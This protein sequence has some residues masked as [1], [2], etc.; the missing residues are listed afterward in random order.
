VTDVLVKAKQIFSLSQTKNWEFI[1]RLSSADDLLWEDKLKQITLCPEFFPETWQVKSWAE[2][3]FTTQFVKKRISSRGAGI[4]FAPLAHE[5]VSDYIV[6]NKLK[7][8]TEY[9]VLTVRGQVL[10]K[11]VIKSSK[12]PSQKIKMLS[13]EN[14]T[15]S[16]LA[17]TQKIQAQVKFELVGYD[18]AQLENGA[19]QLIEINRSPQITNNNYYRFTKINAAALLLATNAD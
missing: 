13:G 16:L 19:Y 4:I 6:Q 14:I 3:D 5:A 10:P 12:T 8:K 1:D 2:I 15:S 18:I 11:V 17:Y 9:R 7:I